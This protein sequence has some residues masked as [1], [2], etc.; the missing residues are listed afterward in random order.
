MHAPPLTRCGPVRGSWDRLVARVLG[1]GWSLRRGATRVLALP[2]GTALRAQGWLLA[3][4]ATTTSAGMVLARTAEVLA[5]RRCPFT[6]AAT[7]SAV[8]ALNA[9][10]A[11]LAVAARFLTIYPNS[12]DDVAEL[13]RELDAATRG[14]PGPVITSA[15]PVCA[16]SLVHYR[17][18]AFVPL[19]R[20]ADSG[21][22]EQVVHA[23]DGSA[24]PDRPELWLPPW[25]PDP[26]G[27]PSA[28]MPNPLGTRFVP[29]GAGD[30]FR[31]LDRSTGAEVVVTRGRAHVD[32]TPAGDLRDRLRAEAAMLALLGPT[33]LVPDLVT[34]HERSGQTFLITSAV[35]G[36][37]LADHVRT[38]S[39]EQRHD[40]AI[41]LTELLAQIH[42]EGVVLRDLSPA[43]VVVEPGGT[44]RLSRL[45][46]A[47]PAG[48]EVTG[49][50]PRGFAA[51]EQLAS[52]AVPTP[53][54]PAADL[55][56]L[57]AMLFFL[58]VGAEP[59]LAKEYPERGARGRLRP[60]LDGAAVDNP[61]VR[62][63]R[64]LILDL[65]ADDPQ[66]RCGLDAV[67]ERLTRRVV[68]PAPPAAR[69]GEE[70]ADELVRDG[71]G[72]LLAA[73]AGPGADRLWP[74]EANTDPTIVHCGSAGVL[75]ALV[76]AMP[77]L[78]DGLLFD[79]VQRAAW[80]TADRC[81]EEPTV[82]PGLHHGR[83]GVV[84]SLLEAAQA[85]QDRRLRD[86]ALELA[87]DI[88]VHGPD[89]GVH[90]GIAGAGLAML[91][92]WRACGDPALLG[93]AVR[94]AEHLLATVDDTEPVW[95]LPDAS[96]QTGF[97]EG[98]AGIA[99]FLLDCWRA[100]E[101]ERYLA[102]ARRAADFLCGQAVHDHAG[103]GTFLVRAWA[104]TGDPRHLETAQAIATPVRAEQWTR[105]PT[106]ANGVAGG[107]DF[108]LDL[109]EATGDPDPRDAA[110]HGLAALRARTTHRYGRTVV[111]DESGR[112]AMAGHDIGVAGVLS[113]VIR[114]RH[115]GSRPWLPPVTPDEE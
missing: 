97:A 51:P 71:V 55:F 76:R 70:A 64:P 15:R 2:D 79:A 54:D 6:F 94:C 20:L 23:P 99:T 45:A 115:G 112:T 53:A 103:T 32:E 25:S 11:D 73:M 48:A 56:S 52:A 113:T 3:V 21:R 111:C 80:W 40:L 8:R 59:V 84:W 42:F 46:M 91:H 47:A 50:G 93:K 57:G 77:Y 39:G 26:I 12:D 19:R 72:Y 83:S 31:A 65:V 4:S 44:L 63:Y 36:T 90:R 106:V 33:G 1:D 66:D 14:L 88:P 108:L 28:P 107:M 18:A 5:A 38:L 9:Q 34:V 29:R 13:A 105:P 62:R 30:R 95:W 17:Y 102:I 110:W 37:P 68:A 81:A 96:V 92:C 60:W 22:Y 74:G 101:D 89:P 98:T 10:D 16:G 67:A 49:A 7:I 41:Q 114:L 78:R 69:P 82:L 61:L 85:V 86:R 35:E 109:A 27:A 100:T 75:N 87:G 58:A 43:T 24:V 104:A